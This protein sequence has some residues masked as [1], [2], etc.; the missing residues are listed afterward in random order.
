M[1]L[2]KTQSHINPHWR[3]MEGKEK[4]KDNVDNIMLKTMLGEM[5]FQNGGVRTSNILIIHKSKKKIL[6]KSIFSELWKLTKGLKQSVESDWISEQ[7]PLWCFN[8]SYSSSIITWKT[9]SLLVT[10]VLK[11]SRLGATGIAE[12]I[13]SSK[14]VHF[15]ENCHY[16]TH[17]AAPWILPIHKVCLHLTWL[18]TCSVRTAISPGQFLENAS[19]NCLTWELHEWW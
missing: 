9:N 7:Q 19:C 15:P 18:R 17:L 11:T 10:V 5:Q 14:K 12:R 1:L 6:S 8:P 13:Q 16:I 2:S 4:Q 3:E